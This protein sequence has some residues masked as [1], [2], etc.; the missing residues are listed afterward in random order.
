M[1][2]CTSCSVRVSIERS[3]F[4]KNQ[5]RRVGHCGAGNGQQLALALAEVGTIA[6]Q[7]CLIPLGRRR[8][9][10]SALARRAAGGI[11]RRWPK[12]ARTEYYP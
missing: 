10:L 3:R 1:P 7:H 12:G 8:I 11:L 9:K 6:G 4:V 5:H 2:C